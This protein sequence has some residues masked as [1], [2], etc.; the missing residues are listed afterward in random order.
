MAKWEYRVITIITE[1]EKDKSGHRETAK[2]RD[3]RIE[4]R[5]SEMGAD[6]WELVNFVPVALPTRPA[7]PWIH[8]AIFKR[9][10]KD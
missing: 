5:L 2:E 3:D 6:G 10:A 4:N 8:H 7:N 1:S 9:Q